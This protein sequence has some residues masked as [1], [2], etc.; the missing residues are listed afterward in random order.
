MKTAPDIPGNT[1]WE[2]LGNAVEM[3]FQVPKDDV[4]KEENRLK[5]KRERKR[6]KA[7]NGHNGHAHPPSKKRAH[8]AGK[9]KGHEARVGH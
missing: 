5:R 8:E 6:A 4:V 9:V 3:V 1:P 2:R 7:A